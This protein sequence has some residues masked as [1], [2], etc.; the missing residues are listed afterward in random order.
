MLRLAAWRMCEAGIVPSML[1]HDAVLL[2]ARDMKQVEHVKE[3]MRQ[4]GRDV[5]RGL[6]VGVAADQ[7]L[8]GGARYQDK[9]P[10]AR[11]MW[12]VIMQTLQEIG[13]IPRDEILWVD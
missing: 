6:D 3:I 9:R 11:R 5:C 10:M 4:A 8:R 12:L 2:E 13:A 1:V 7:L